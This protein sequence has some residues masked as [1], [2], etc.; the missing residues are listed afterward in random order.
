M[1]SKQKGTILEHRIPKEPTG[2]PLLLGNKIDA[3]V[4]KYII[5]S[6]NRG[7]V[8]SSSIA[9]STAKALVSGNPGYVGQIDLE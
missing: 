8:I 3:I 6:S 4:Q 7:K 5:A 9:T 2:Q 1:R